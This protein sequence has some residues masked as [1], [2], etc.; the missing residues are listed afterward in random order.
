MFKYLNNRKNRKRGQSALEYS[1]LLIVIIGALL[2]IQA[3]IKRSVAGRLK[4]ASDDIGKQFSVGQTNAITMRMTNSWTHD[5]FQYGVSKS[6]LTNEEVTLTLMNW[7]IINV[8]REYWGN[9]DV[10]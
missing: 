5:T 8:D 10:R 3:Y 4:E 7:D 6:R 2:S 9:P 1:I